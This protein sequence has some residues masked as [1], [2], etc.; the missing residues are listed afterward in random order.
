MADGLVHCVEKGGWYPTDLDLKIV[1][2]NNYYN[3]LDKRGI[4]ILR[5][6]LL[7]DKIFQNYHKIGATH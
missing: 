3:A 5:H 6:Y 4:I 1:Y 2:Y 7:G